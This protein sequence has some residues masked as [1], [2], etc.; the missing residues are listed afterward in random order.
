MAHT[1]MP[2][3]GMPTHATPLERPRLRLSCINGTL[4]R[5][6][7]AFQKCV[8]S[9]NG[10]CHF[11]NTERNLRLGSK[12][13]FSLKTLFTRLS[14]IRRKHNARGMT[15]ILDKSYLG[16]LVDIYLLSLEDTAGYHSGKRWHLQLM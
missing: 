9:Q 13:N 12:L 14:S 10:R 5:F 1:L 8:L 3:P 7:S 6:F 16:L 4:P 2:L 11:C 15:L